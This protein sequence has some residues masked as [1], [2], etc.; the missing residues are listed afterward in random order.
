MNTTT[1]RY[2]ARGLRASWA[3][4]VTSGLHK[5]HGPVWLQWLWTLLFCA[6]L[7]VFFTL[8]GFFAFA[9][10]KSAWAN[11]SGWLYWYGK[12]F[13][14]SL[15]I[16]VVIHLMFD[17]ARLWVGPQRV[18]RWREWQRTV[19]FSGLPML[20]VVLGWPVG[21][22]LAGQDVTVWVS[23][24]NGNSIIVGTVLLSLCITFVLHHFFAAKA[25]QMEAEKRATEAQL[26][27]LQGQIEP[28][29]LF[30]TLA[31]VQSLMADDVA[32]A[33]QMLESFTDYLRGSLTALRR[34]HATLGSETDL[35]QAYLTLLQMRMGER[36]C[37][38]LD[39]ADSLRSVPLPPLLLQPLVENAIHHGLEPKVEGGQITVRARH[40]G[41]TL[42]IEV[43]DNGLGLD[44][45]PRPR[46]GAGVALAN[47]RERLAA[48]YHGLASLTL[49]PAPQGTGTVATLRLPLENA[50]P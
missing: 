33:S 29:F 1:F 22:W 41:D 16:G 19:F 18:A 34:E 45:P 46:R 37:F 15:T 48:Q 9:S 40:E 6:G 36:L 26:R 20:G 30:N 4:W 38:V 25:R 2:D 7:A 12:N 44:A 11:W 3:S 8:L 35:L 13:V 21:V 47:L 24:R 10:G 32:K 17:L 39:V 42:V 28:H 50:A 49:G 31:N 27:L 43:L 5:P 14:V 23:S